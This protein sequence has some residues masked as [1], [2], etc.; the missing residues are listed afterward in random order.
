MIN[1]YTEEEEKRLDVI[2]ERLVIEEVP[3]WRMMKMYAEFLRGCILAGRF[4]KAAPLAQLEFVAEHLQ[5]AIVVLGA[6]NSDELRMPSKLE[7]WSLSDRFEKENPIQAALS[8]CAV[9]CF[10][11]ES[12]WDPGNSE[13]L[14]PI[15][16]FLFLLKRL[17]PDMGAEF[18]MYAG[19][20][21][22]KPH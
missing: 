1:P 5:R 13:S 12:G 3:F 7:L 22:L 19:K 2:E 4:D 20:Y 9:C 17:D 6:D 14:T 8:R 15:P 16:L 10:Y 11:E 18:L 21:L